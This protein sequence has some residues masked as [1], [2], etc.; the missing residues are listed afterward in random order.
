MNAI[1]THHAR[2][3]MQQRGISPAVIDCLLRFGSEQYDRHGGVV[4]FFDKAARRRLLRDGR[5]SPVEMER[6]QGVYAVVSHEGSV[7]TTGHRRRRVRR[8]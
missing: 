4:V 1:Y 3:R 5:L 8:L 6:M 2:A 7:V